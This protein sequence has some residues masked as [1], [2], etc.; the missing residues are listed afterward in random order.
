MVLEVKCNG[1][2]ICD[3]AAISCGHTFDDLGTWAH[4]FYLGEKSN[5]W[6]FRF[7]YTSLN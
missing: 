4:V 7:Y 2:M 6:E 3:T 1:F 5:Y